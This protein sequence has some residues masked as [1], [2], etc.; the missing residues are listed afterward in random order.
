MRSFKSFIMEST[1]A[2]DGHPILALTHE[3]LDARHGGHKKSDM[4]DGLTYQSSHPTEDAGKEHHAQVRGE[5]HGL[6]WQTVHH[7]E[8]KNRAYDEEY[9]T[10]HHP[11]A[12]DHQVNIVKWGLRP[13][14]EVHN[15]DS[16]LSRK[17]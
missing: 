17:E 1:T 5:L 15:V 3:L 4:V 14:D 13:P 7:S 2:L 10:F 11:D 6:G 9:E 8:D 16:Y 12:P